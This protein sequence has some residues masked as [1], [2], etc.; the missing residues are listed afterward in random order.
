MT[1]FSNLPDLVSWYEGYD[2][3]HNI[4]PVKEPVKDGDATTWGRPIYL[5]T[6]ADAVENQLLIPDNKDINT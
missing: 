3:S 4:H 5:D 1:A 6:L 2:V